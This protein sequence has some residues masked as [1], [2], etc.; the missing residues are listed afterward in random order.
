MRFFSQVKAHEKVLPEAYMKYSEDKI[1][2][3]TQRFEQKTMLETAD[4]CL[5]KRDYKWR[6]H[7]TKHHYFIA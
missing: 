5:L 2:S 4:F 6:E 7:E 1:L 3:E